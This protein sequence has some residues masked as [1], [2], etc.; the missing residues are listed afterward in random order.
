MLAGADNPMIEGLSSS[1]AYV[2]DVTAVP[3]ALAGAI[4]AANRQRY[5]YA[6]PPHVA[7]LMREGS[8]VWN[9]LEALRDHPKHGPR[10]LVAWLHAIAG[11]LRGQP[12]AT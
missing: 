2:D 1:W 9:V 3:R 4:T 6:A 8:E 7:A 11:A 10:E 5:T 12:A